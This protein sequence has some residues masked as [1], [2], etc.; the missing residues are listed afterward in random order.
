M[1]DDD[2][3]I[4]AVGDVFLDRPDPDSAFGAAEELFAAADIRFANNE[5]AYADGV[6][7]VPNA[8]PPAISA[9]RNAAALRRAGFDVMSVANN[10]IL[11]AGYPGLRSTLSCLREA[12][13]TPVG[14]GVDRAAAYRPVVVHRNGRRIAFLAF[15][16]VFPAGYEARESLPGLAPLRAHNAYLPAIMH[17]WAPGMVP[18]V[19]S[20]LDGTDAE[21]AEEAIRGAR[22]QADTVVVSCHWGDFS[23]PYVITDL[24]RECAELFVEAGADVVLGHHQHTLRGVHFHD[25][26]PVMHGLGHWAMDLPGMGDWLAGEG[27]PM[28]GPEAV[29]LYGDHGVFPRKDYPLLP[30]HPDAR[31]TAATLVRIPPSGKAEIVIVPAYIEP[32]GRTVPVGPDRAEGM[33]VADYL[34]AACGT[35]TN[36]AIGDWQQVTRTL[37]G[38]PV[39]PPD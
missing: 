14:A 3:T 2:V 17:E 25:G 5:G 26:R 4:L 36:A 24:E 39:L 6:D 35:H 33:R 34:R 9:R 13:A 16:C 11:D 38:L 8:R 19:I 27:L 1:A 29:A 12:G 28:E 31:L 7:P 21:R 22:E 18:R 15:S 32:S 37:A 10:H 30:F 23:R 20:L